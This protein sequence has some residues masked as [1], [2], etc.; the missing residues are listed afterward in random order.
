MNNK[1]CLLVIDA[2]NGMFDLPRKLYN[3]N[4]ILNNI[5]SLIEKS[6]KENAIIIYMQHYGNENS[7]FKEGSEGWKIHPKVLPRKNDIVLKKTHS[8]SF[9]NTKLDD[10]LKNKKINNLV[11]CGFVTEGCVDTTI[12]R[13]SSLGY[14]L[15]VASNSHSTTD[16]NILSAEQIINHHNEVFKLFSSV[17]KSEEIIFKV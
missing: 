3:G 4:V 8:D 10:I 16:S 6:R 17:K 13:A 2:Q 5:I 1:K 12:R 14:N 7:F 11:I 9:Q 15:E